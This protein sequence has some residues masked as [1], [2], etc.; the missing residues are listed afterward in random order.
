MAT[1]TYKFRGTRDADGRFSLLKR[2]EGRPGPAGERLAAGV[3]KTKCTV[4]L[5]VLL[6]ALLLGECL[7]IF[8]LLSALPQL[9]SELAS[10]NDLLLHRYAIGHASRHDVFLDHPLPLNGGFPLFSH[11]QHLPH[12]V[13]VLLQR[14]FSESYANADTAC[15]FM[16]A[17][18]PL[19][20]Y[21]GCRRVGLNAPAA[22]FVA[23]LYPIINDMP[24]PQNMRQGITYSYGLGINS[25][26]HVGHGLWS[27]LASGFL[28]FPSLGLGFSALASHAALLPKPTGPVVNSS[29]GA[30]GLLF[31]TSSSNMFYGYM[32]GASSG[33]LD[34]LRVGDG[35]AEQ[36][37]P[38][39]SSVPGRFRGHHL[40]SFAGLFVLRR[41]FS[42]Q[43]SCG[44]RCRAS[45]VEI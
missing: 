11:Y 5:E 15:L 24:P 7:W 19:G 42:T 45:K 37:A 2:D 22:C 8:R 21:W 39:R 44:V 6:V 14:V 33:S 9:A 10:H 23:L 43:P 20:I 41:P 29:V 1:A 36:S 13:V 27:Q 28:L 12:V 40:H 18:M 17:L 16:L 3:G 25:Y 35:T 4:R 38:N 30:A 26:L 31:A 34:M 32:V